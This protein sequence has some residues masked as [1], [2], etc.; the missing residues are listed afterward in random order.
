[1]AQITTMHTECMNL[2]GY[3]CEDI[4]SWIANNR[5]NKRTYDTIH[6]TS[7]VDDYLLIH[8][9]HIVAECDDYSNIHECVKKLG[10][11]VS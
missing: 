4:A 1:M 2:P 6:L 11:D 7:D 5:S 10:L 3:L 8:Y 9:P